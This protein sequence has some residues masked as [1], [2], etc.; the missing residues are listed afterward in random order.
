[1][2]SKLNGKGGGSNKNHMGRVKETARRQVKL[3]K[4]LLEPQV[5]NEDRLERD[6]MASGLDPNSPAYDRDSAHTWRYPVSSAHMGRWLRP[7]VRDTDMQIRKS[8]VGQGVQQGGQ[9][10][11]A[12]PYGMM[13]VGTV[14]TQFMI[15]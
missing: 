9:G 13:T 7:D 10:A 6:R 4:K 15:H 5:V 2:A 1:M 3:D 12:T 8:I 11:G 14:H